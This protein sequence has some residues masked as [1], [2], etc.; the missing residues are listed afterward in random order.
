MR[1]S[2]ES[3]QHLKTLLQTVSIPKIDKIIIEDG[4]VRGIDPDQTVVIISSTNVPDFGGKSVGLN[5]LSTLA[6]RLNLLDG[7]ELTVEAVEADNSI[8]GFNIATKGSKFQYKCARTDT[9]R[10]PKTIHDNFIWSITIPVEAV[11]LTIS[12]C[13]TID[14]EQIALCSKSNGEV[15]FEIIDSITR[16]TFTTIIATEATWKGDEDERQ[17]QAF[18]HYYAIKTLI[19]LLKQIA[20]TGSSELV[21]GEGGVLQITVNGHTFS[22]LPRED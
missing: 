12:A 9:I 18:V 1:L 5:R 10:A 3:V 2:K 21:V 16:D 22:L 15:Y 17:T 14:S 19:P 13:N 8:S 20:S 7:D 11:K 6:S 4:K